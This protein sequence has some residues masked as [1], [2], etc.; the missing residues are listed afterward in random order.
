[1]HTVI[2]LSEWDCNWEQKMNRYI[3]NYL[4]IKSFSDCPCLTSRNLPAAE[5]IVTNFRRH[6]IC[7][8]HDYEWPFS[9]SLDM[10][11]HCIYRMLSFL[12]V[13]TFVFWGEHCCY[14]LLNPQ[15]FSSLKCF[16]TLN[17][18]AAKAL[19]C[20]VTKWKR[21]LLSTFYYTVLDY[22]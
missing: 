12:F 14:G 1:M 11:P 15:L 8:I 2:F 5:F 10:G 18:Q 7:L 19:T 21:M 16:D 4:H 6:Q 3:W 22:K 20:W 13:F 9:G 17:S